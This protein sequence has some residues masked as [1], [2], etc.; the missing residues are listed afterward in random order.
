MTMRSQIVVAFFVSLLA[1]Q[2]AGQSGYGPVPKLDFPRFEDYKVA[3]PQPSR[4]NPA[5]RQ[6]A[7]RSSNAAEKR[8]SISS[9]SSVFAGHFRL[10]KSNC[11]T[12]CIAITIVDTLTARRYGTP[13]IGVRPC[14]PDNLDTFIWRANSRLLVI[15]GSLEVS[16]ESGSWPC[17]TAFYEWR[18]SDFRLI[19]RL[20]SIQRM[21]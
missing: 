20:P 14:T 5:S 11:G 12:A 9:Q 7:V 6:T 4:N 17:G 10:Q 1:V 21:H 3:A 13:F 8:V 2:L 16:D 15:N 19:R 18:G